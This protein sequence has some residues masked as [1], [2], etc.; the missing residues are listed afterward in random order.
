MIIN[1]LQYFANFLAILNPTFCDEHRSEMVE[2]HFRKTGMRELALHERHSAVLY[3]NNSIHV[4]EFIELAHFVE[5][6]N[7]EVS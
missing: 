7:I 1:V 5:S 3:S 2:T 4:I 6:N